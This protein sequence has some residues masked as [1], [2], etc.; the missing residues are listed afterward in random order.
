MYH[1][2]VKVIDLWA[3]AN[4]MRTDKMKFV[5]VRISDEGS[6]SFTATTS[7]DDIEAVEYDPID[8]IDGNP[9]IS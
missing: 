6:L 8:P 7:K 9:T 5:E 2:T 4:L 1:S 3:A